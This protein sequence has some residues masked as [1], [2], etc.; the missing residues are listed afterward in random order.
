MFDPSKLDLDLNKLDNEN[1]T[2]NLDSEAIKIDLNNSNS[3]ETK[4]TPTTN[5][6][7]DSLNISE[8]LNVSDN[9]NVIENFYT[10]DINELVDNNQ[11]LW[12]NDL[13]EV[14][15]LPKENI[16]ES[17]NTQSEIKTDE[18]IW[19][20]EYEKNIWSNTVNTEANNQTN[21]TNTSSTEEKII[22][23][24]NITTLEI[25]LEIL[26]EKQYDFATFEPSENYVTINFRKDKIVKETKYIKYPIYSNILIKAKTLT[27]LTIEETE[28]EQEWDG[29]LMIKDKNY[30]IITKVVPSVH[31][32][33]LF[34]K[35]KE[36]AKKLTTKEVKKV[37]IGKIF[38]YLW[39]I[40]FIAL[41]VW[42]AF[43]A[44]VV[45]NANTVDDVKFFANLWISL[46]DI[47]NFI[48]KA[49]TLIFSI[50]I[51]IEVLFLIM[52]LAKFLL[53]KKEFK[54][55][56]I[57]YGILWVLILF[58]A[59]G[60]GSGWMIL[61]KKIRSLPNWQEM[62]YWD[63]QIYDNSKLTSKFYD[64]WSSLIADTS[65]IIWPMQIKYDVSYLAKNEERK[66]LKIKKYVWDFWDGKE[67][68]SPIPTIIHDFKEKW[69]Y[70]VKLKL[71]ETNVNWEEVEKPVE[72]IPWINIA[73]V[74]KINEK[75]LNNG[76]KLVDF[77]AT[78]LKE[79]GKLEW[80]FLEDLEKP[81]WSW[82]VFRIWK[83]IFEDTF[84]WLYIKRND[85]TSTDL[86]KIFIVSWK[87]ETKLWWEIKSDKSIEND[88]E[89]EFRVENAE[90]DFWNWVIEEYKWIIWDKEMTKIWDP[91]NQIEASKIKFTFENYWE[92]TVKVILK[93]SS[94]EIK[95]ITTKVD[96]PKML[97]LSN[98]L[99]V[100]DNWVN[101]ENLKY[102]KKLHEYF[103]DEIWVP[104]DLTIDARFIK[105][106]NL[107]YTVKKVSFDYNSD[108][109]VDEVT[110]VW[111]Y[112]A[113]TEWNH[114]ITVIFEFENRKDKTD[115]ITM[116][117]KIF[118]EWIKKEAILNFEINKNSPYVPVTVSFDAS[119]SQVKN[120]NIDKFIWDYGD[121]VT[122][123]RD[124]IV[125]WHKYTSPW[126][127]TIKLKVITTSWKDYSI[128]KK[129]V[130]KPKPQTV[131]IT[132]SM[133]KAPVWQG[134]DF[135]SE[136]S[137]WQIVWYYWDFW[138][139]MSSTEANPTHAY[140]N[141]G[142][143][144][145]ILKLDFAN[146]NI[147]E[148]TTSVEVVE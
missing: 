48:L 34:I 6:I 32:S 19:K 77:D 123:E 102:E 141:P 5:D 87:S 86:D 104:T 99:K 70:E 11:T 52:Y 24:I 25:F 68:D 78:T 108:W 109:D 125:E 15:D 64:K 26:L 93:D 47:N 91:T 136:D 12:I 105:A 31:G 62:A 75:Q 98:P 33:K 79:L 37:S 45:M 84:V 120:E 137:E 4:T 130:L 148:D 51:F 145:V 140:K 3:T 111:K 82:D 69:N 122:E 115:L 18:Q 2:N 119:K 46:N 36:E 90:T 101:V 14:L 73:Y 21:S 146:R 53:T 85:K 97:L 147:L 128:S 106:N 27:K 22:Y 135:L 117:E 129:L 76:W 17:S 134:I 57:R 38:M 7:L 124:G 30:K 40:A 59:F 50:I 28:N 23:D 138:D 142:K 58:L 56:K 9:L 88:L 71:T 1:N 89:Y 8:K 113:S 60:S 44:F 95:E 20:T 41:I 55:K 107:L 42:W 35:I 143:Y 144:K 10:K 139:G 29:E 110:K 66:W 96:I 131:K 127:Y 39:V 126:E 94:W 16:Q 63:I 116:K 65:N 43:M 133:S 80:Y 49:V 83:P 100:Q 74:V 103:I 121:G 72:N 67:I 132:T 114:T 13:M 118:I 112:T 92:Q 61:D 54:Q 81:V